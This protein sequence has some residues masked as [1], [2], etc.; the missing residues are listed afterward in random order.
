MKSEIYTNRYGDKFI[1]TP[2]EDGNVLWEGKFE[3]CRFGYPNDYTNAYQAYITNGGLM[4]LKEFIEEVHRSIYGTN[5]EY[6]SPSDISQIYGSLVESK[7]D[8]INMVDPSG[9]P[10]LAEGM[11]STLAHPE[12]KEKFISHFERTENG[13]KIILK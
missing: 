5:G 6:I 4:N 12:I 3:W 11:P 10:Y 13:Y 1:F 7:K 2:T 9:G 8:I